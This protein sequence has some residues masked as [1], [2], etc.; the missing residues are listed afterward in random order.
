MFSAAISAS[1]TVMP[2][3]LVTFI[4][5]TGDRKPGIGGGA[6][7]RLD[8]DKIADQRLAAPILGDK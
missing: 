5:A 8:N 7:D 6:G 1:V 3:C 4:K 2:L